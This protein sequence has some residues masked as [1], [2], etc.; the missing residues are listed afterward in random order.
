MKTAHAPEREP[1]PQAAGSGSEPP[2]EGPP[3]ETQSLRRVGKG[4]A[5]GLGGGLTA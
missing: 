3:P 4:G 5:P 1:S 2:Q